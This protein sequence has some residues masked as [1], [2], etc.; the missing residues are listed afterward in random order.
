MLGYEWDEEKN[1]SNLEKHG[2]SFEEAID[3]F[4]GPTLSQRTVRAGEIRDISFGLLGRSV[5]VTVIHTDRN[6]R[7]RIIS[8]RKASKSE[9]R[10]FHDHLKKAVG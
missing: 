7:T 3:I 10:L 5:V 6:G 8:A 1:A 4:D 9:R 2:I